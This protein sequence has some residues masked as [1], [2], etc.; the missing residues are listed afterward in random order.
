[1]NKLFTFNNEEKEYIKKEKENHENTKSAVIEIIKFIQKKYNW[2][3]DEHI[4]SIAKIL[5]ITNIELEEI[6]TFYSQ[7]FRKPI[8]K[9]IIRY[10]DSIVCYINN[11]KIV[12]K[13]I[14]NILKIKPGETTKDKKFTL[15]PTCCLGNCDKSPVIMIN[16]NTYTNMQPNKISMLLNKYK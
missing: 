6:T 4:N 9:N 10:C 16:N 8:G 11:Y 1:M 15:L 2:V 5:N 3:S 12:Q 14:E 7:I 13:E